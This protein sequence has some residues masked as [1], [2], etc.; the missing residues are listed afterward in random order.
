MKLMDGVQIRNEFIKIYQKTIQENQLDICLVIIQVGDDFSSNTYVKNKVKYAELL[1]IQTQVMKLEETITEEELIQKI[2]QLNNDSKVTGILLQSPT[3][4]HI[5]F[6]KCVRMIS[7]SK[8]VDALTEENLFAL[9]DHQEKILPC[10]VKGILTLLEYYSI[11]LEGKRV[12]VVGR[13]ALVGRPLVDAL[14]NRD[15]TVTLCHSKTI[16]LEAITKTADILICTVGKPNFITKDMVKDGFIGIDVGINYLDGK[17]TGDFSKEVEE[18]AS[19]LTPVPG[20]VGPMTV[21]MVINNLIELKM[22]TRK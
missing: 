5:D 11:P 1:G 4:K 9:R 16:N 15:A 21:A 14:I 22:K 19:Y 12:V 18:K 7:P 20:G 13:S 10:T 6:I 3:P 17:I 8:D 2:E